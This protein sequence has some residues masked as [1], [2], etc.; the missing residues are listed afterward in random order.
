MKNNVLSFITAI[1]SVVSVVLC[2]LVIVERNDKQELAERNRELEASIGEFR[3]K[4]E[5][6]EEARQRETEENAKKDEPLEFFSLA[7]VPYQASAYM[8]NNY[9]GQVW[10]M[11]A[12]AP[13]QKTTDGKPVYFPV[14][15]IDEGL[16]GRF[17]SIQTNVVERAVVRNVSNYDQDY[18]YNWNYNRFRRAPTAPT[19]P[20]APVAPSPPSHPIAPPA[21]PITP[22]PF[23][24]P[25]PITDRPRTVIP[26]RGVNTSSVTM[27][28][29]SVQPMK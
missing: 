13:K 12:E 6:L 8:G 4:I 2:T 29:E 10:I 28:L 20:S 23:V 5:S 9:L 11:H 19:A 1:L 24:P 18:Y 17:T 25:T 26:R 22:P 14:V 3:E 16:K 7:S 21:Q 15:R 27:K